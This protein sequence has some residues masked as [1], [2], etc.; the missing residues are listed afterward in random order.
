MERL[1]SSSSRLSKS[2]NI[3]QNLLSALI[4]PSH[5][6]SKI[7]AAVGEEVGSG[8]SYTSLQSSSTVKQKMVY[9]LLKL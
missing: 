2:N 7:L 4:Y 3:D 6:A 1:H 9:F 8:S 5:S